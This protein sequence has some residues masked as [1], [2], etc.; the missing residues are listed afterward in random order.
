MRSFSSFRPGPALTIW[1]PRFIALGLVLLMATI[2]WPAMPAATGMAL[3]AL[4]AT[5]ATVTR[6]A[7]SP[8][9]QLLLLLHLTVYGGLYALCSGARLDLLM[10]DG[11]NLRV[12]VLADLAASV[13]PAA[14]ALYL[15]ANTLIGQ[16]STD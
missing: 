10:N 15:T 9:F 1:A 11:S 16:P 4:G 12:P 3:I 7:G 2:Y 14:A 13:W 6:F 8:G 5:G